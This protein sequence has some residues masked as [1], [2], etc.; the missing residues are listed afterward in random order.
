L[1]DCQQLIAGL[2]HARE[3]VREAVAGVDDGTASRP[4]TD[5]WSIKD[6]LTHI[7]LW[8]EMR[9]FEIS[10]IARGGDYS[11]PTSGEDGITPL[12]EAFVDN[13]RRL[14]LG[15]VVAD[16]EFAWEMVQQ[17]VLACPEDRLP[18]RLYG[19]IG[20]SG[21]AE[22]DIEHAEAITALRK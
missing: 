10:R 9:F 3:R 11:F 5:G 14:A 2:E 12:N 21:G 20:I 18:V 7:T 15:Q 13:R 16:L 1:T 8:H 4:G 19:E 22:H 6:H 17:A